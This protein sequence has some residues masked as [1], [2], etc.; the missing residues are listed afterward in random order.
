MK[1]LLSP[2]IIITI[3]MVSCTS[4][5]Q[6]KII[7]REEQINQQVSRMDL[8]SF[9][10]YVL[11]N[12]TLIFNKRMSD[13]PIGKKD[14]VYLVGKWFTT[15]SGKDAVYYLVFENQHK[16]FIYHELR[17]YNAQKELLHH[18]NL[19]DTTYIF[20][21][22]ARRSSHTRWS[23]RWITIESGVRLH[24]TLAILKTEKIDISS[25]LGPETDFYH[26]PKGYKFE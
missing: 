15:N 4:D 8:K 14:T 3:S 22:P 25:M 18:M 21:S 1:N 24:D 20:R 26:Y 16:R 9:D 13:A 10:N 23:G 5:R 11:A 17:V 19:T 7:D 6:P 2:I 12:D